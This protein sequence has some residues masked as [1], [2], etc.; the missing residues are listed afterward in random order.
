MSMWTIV[1]KWAI[2]LLVGACANPAA[3]APT[4]CEAQAI[5]LA[6]VTWKSGQF[7][8]E[9]IRFILQNGYGCRTEQVDGTTGETEAALAQGRLQLWVEIWGDNAS[10][11]VKKAV[12]ARQVRLVGDLLQGGSVEGWFVPEYVVKGDPKRKLAP[13]APDLVSVTDLARYKHLFPDPNDPQKGQFLNCPV[14]WECEKDNNQKLKAYGLQGSFN[15]YRPSSGAVLD[16]LIAA[17]IA[18]D[19]PMVFYYWSPAAL[20]AQFRLVR[21]KEPAFDEACWKTIHHAT[22]DKP[23]GSATPPSTLQV[24][25]STPFAQAAPEIVE[26]LSKVQ[27]TPELVNKSIF[28]MTERR[29][30][31]RHEAVNFLK[32]HP[33]VWQAW[34]P[35]TVA[36]RVTESL[37]RGD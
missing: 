28:R 10:E 30:S 36:H 21:L 7:Y 35:V 24:G 4:W 34:V 33:Q 2:P 15:Q 8:T 20:M 16:L 22:V 19:K 5:K 14:G 27:L 6:G 12:A 3:A 13:M 25:V 26:F 23:C 31:G 29:L 32:A 18:V 17:G 11:T 1:R 9:V 37:Q